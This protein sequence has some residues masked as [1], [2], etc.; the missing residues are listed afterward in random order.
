MTGRVLTAW[1]H[2]T[3]ICLPRDKNPPFRSFP[4]HLKK[5]RTLPGVTAA[6]AALLLSLAACGSDSTGPS[7]TVD[8]TAALNS[9]ALGIGTDAASGIYSPESLVSFA[10]QLDH[11]NVTIDGKSQSMFALGM[12]E[13][14]PAGTC[15]ETLIVDP[16]IIN[17]PGQCTPPQFTFALI[18]WQSHSADTPPDRL[19]LI[20]GDVG[21][22]NFADVTTGTGASPAF[23]LYT[24]GQDV[25]GI[26]VAGTLTSNVSASSQSCAVPLPPYAKSGSCNVAAF[27]EQGTVN[28]EPV[29]GTTAKDIVISRQTIDGI[30][31][32]ITETQ[33][34]TLPG[35]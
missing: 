33:T 1:E 28:F 22:I 35:A 26:S 16:T 18:L 3:I 21:S 14:Y 25:V 11:I 23:A 15:Q 8:A 17:P 6:C 29:T 19:A 10:P 13:T 27:D 20:V 34:V 9:L 24:E 2:V 12:R 30:W 4:M 32:T 7:T 31:L 5:A